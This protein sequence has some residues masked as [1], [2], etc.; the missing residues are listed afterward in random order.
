MHFVVGFR[1]WFAIGNERSMI[2]AHT[3]QYFARHEIPRRQRRR[4]EH[5]RVCEVS[6]LADVSGSYIVAVDHLLAAQH[7]V[8]IVWMVLF[9]E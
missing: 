3:R 7:F 1:S 2:A 6:G 4:D 5:M 9:Q 8:Q